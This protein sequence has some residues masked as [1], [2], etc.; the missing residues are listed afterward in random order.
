M[1]YCNLITDSSA[2]SQKINM[3]CNVIPKNYFTSI[4]LPVLVCILQSTKY[5]NN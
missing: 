3:T 1:V 2:A 5:L 4:T